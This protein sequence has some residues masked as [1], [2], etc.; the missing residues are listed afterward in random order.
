MT[1]YALD[2]LHANLERLAHESR[3][4]QTTFY[5]IYANLNEHI[6]LRDNLL[7]VAI[8][9]NTLFAIE[10]RKRFIEELSRVVKPQGVILVVD[11][12][13][14]F[15][16]TGPMDGEIVTPAEAATL[17]REQGFQIGETIPA[18]THHFAFAAL[19][20]TP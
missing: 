11:W 17:F 20:M 14:S 9:A 12:M 16:N 3:A 5:P 19:C 7:S 1:V 10:N 6:P 2:S 18:G 15:G 13:G 4:L 8:V